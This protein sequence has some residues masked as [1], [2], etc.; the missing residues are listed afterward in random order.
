LTCLIGALLSVLIFSSIRKGER[1]R[2]QLDFERQSA[3]IATSL[4][5]G[6]DE[7][8][9]VLRSIQGFYNTS[10]AVGRQEFRAFV[11]STLYQYPGIQ[12]M[13]WIPRVRVTERKAYEAAARQDGFTDFKFTEKDEKGILKTA[14][15]RE[16]YFPV[17]YV[18]PY[19]GNAAALGF[20]LASEPT[21]MDAMKRARDSDEITSTGQIL[22]IQ[23]DGPNKNGFLVFLPIYRKDASFL[24]VD[25]RRKNLLGFAL[26]VFH[27][28]TLIE[29][30]LADIY[31]PDIEFHI[32]DAQTKTG[33]SFLHHHINW[34]ANADSAVESHKVEKILA[35]LHWETSL[36]VAGENWGILFHPTRDFYLSRYTWYSWG[37]LA[38]GLLLTTLLAAYLLVSLGRT[39]QVQRLVIKRTEDL[40]QAIE[41][42]EA[43]VAEHERTEKARAAAMLEN[44]RSLQKVQLHLERQEALGRVTRNLTQNLNPAALFTE[45]CKSVCQLLDVDFTRFLLVNEKTDS[46]TTAGIFGKFKEMENFSLVFPKGKG[47]VSR[48]VDRREPVFVPDVTGDPA[49]SDHEWGS[50]F[51]VRGYLGVPLLLD[52]RVVGVLN[53]FTERVKEFQPDEIE[54]LELFADQA[55][56]A[57]ENAKA[58]RNIQLHSKRQ[59]ALRKIT[60]NLTQNLDPAALFTEICISVTQLLEV[61]FT[62]LL[63]LEEQAEKFAG[64][65]AFGN[66]EDIEGYAMVIPKGKGIV[67]RVVESKDAVFVR[68]VL[69]DPA[70]MDREW[71][72]KL[73]VKSYLGIPLLRE[74]QVI[75]VLNIFSTRIREFQSDEIE[76]LKVFAEQAVV[77]LENARLYQE[78]RNRATSLEVLDEIA[79]AINSTL[80]L[81][82]LF[83]TT[84]NQVKRAL[85]CERASLRILES[86]KLHISNFLSMDDDK[87]REHYFDTP[88]TIAGTFYEEILHLKEPHYTPDTLKSLHP[89]HRTVASHGLR[90]VINVP[91]LSQGEVIGFLN[92]GSS[93]VDAYL[94]EHSRF[95]RSVGDHLALA[96]RNAELFATV[97]ESNEYLQNLIRNAIDAIIS[98]DLEGRISA[99]NPAAQT[100]YGYAEKEV[101]GKPVESIF[102]E[103]VKG[104][105]PEMEDDHTTFERKFQGKDRIPRE[106]L[107]SMFVI[108][109]ESGQRVG[110]TGIHRDITERKRGEDALRKS[111]EK[112]RT[113]FEDARDAIEIVDQNGYIVDCNQ[114][115][116]DLLGYTREEMLTMGLQDIVSPDKQEAA[117][118][119]ISQIIDEGLATFESINL[120]K[121]GTAVNVEVNATSIEIEGRNHVMYF[122][123]DITDR[124]R[125]EWALR[126][127][128]FCLDSAGVSV[129]WVGSDAQ[130]IYANEAACQKLGYSREELLG[131]MVNDFNPEF[132]P[133]KWQE[134]WEGM[135][136]RDSITIESHHQ[137]KDG[138]VFPV[139]VTVKHMKYGDEEYLCSFAQ[140]ITERK[141]EEEAREAAA[142]EYTRLYTEAQN[143]A[144]S[145]EVLDEISK[146]MNSTLDLRDM[147]KVTVEQVKRAVPCERCGMGTL[148]PD[149]TKISDYFLIDDDPDRAEKFEKPRQVPGL[150]EEMLDSLKPIYFSDTLKSPDP[151]HQMLASHGLRSIINVPIVMEEEVIGF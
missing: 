23:K 26:G 102:P 7:N 129:F 17:Y 75:G 38:A 67:S 69:E 125:A 41:D 114:H 8:I 24:T 1:E 70:W 108:R 94:P 85:P 117:A 46:F 99:W 91:L 51:R 34:P 89:R 138:R 33:R 15:Q 77:V 73:G 66:F 50:K 151:R 49:W 44:T 104:E 134:H 82:E 136:Q 128:Q 42:L 143:R 107:V 124:K 4:Q 103:A 80:N 95:M 64:V 6:I 115:A 62:R 21:R 92:V 149:K 74:G 47:V 56:V 122:L 86:D 109:D 141:K 40:S 116:C 111:E 37:A 142:Q 132:P 96:M 146:A 79:K 53:A 31:A 118:H 48:V 101:L 119:R 139:E 30:L 81:G 105:D 137:S 61:N 16:E 148:S 14:E 43:E 13:E 19:Q 57:L 131:M 36:N 3:V 100:L 27:V 98:T 65:G 144:T 140:D 76:L 87:E 55:V 127:T 58:F 78:T 54:L 150:Y 72:E 68:E 83:K 145:L 113:L 28:R 121:D 147:F 20:D 135:K 110:M 71:A 5:K 130:I 18:E 90:S 126:L 22:L 52:G 39:A 11:A 2:T 93:K 59:E 60:Q 35:S 97:K 12:S 29:V 112:Y 106:I 84:V 88:E 123:R 32:S 45:I 10:K 133:E 25:E 120:T 63:V 9:A